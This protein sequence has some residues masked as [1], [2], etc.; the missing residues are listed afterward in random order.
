MNNDFLN[1]T[2]I[3]II[4]Y[5]YF[6]FCLVKVYKPLPIPN[7]TAGY[8]CDIMH[9][10]R[11]LLNIE[12]LF[13]IDHNIMVSPK[14]IYS[15]IRFLWC[16][17][18]DPFVKCKTFHIVNNLISSDINNFNHQFYV[19]SFSRPWKMIKQLFLFNIYKS[20]IFIYFERQTVY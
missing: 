3:I 8:N 5:C 20:I 18:K 4:K 11:Y 16:L 12:L 6:Y 2:H 10:N 15:P 14:S 1:A 13:I 9:L 7:F 19:S 17:N